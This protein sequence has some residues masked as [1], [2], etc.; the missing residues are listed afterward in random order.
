VLIGPGSI[1]EAHTENEKVAKA[2]LLEAVEIYAK[3]VRHLL[4]RSDG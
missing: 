4:A 3:L 2:D 1:H